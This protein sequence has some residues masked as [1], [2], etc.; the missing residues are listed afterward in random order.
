MESCDRGV[1]EKL[2]PDGKAEIVVTSMGECGGCASKESC[3]IMK[4]KN[5]VITARY[6]GELTK[7]DRVKIIVS[8]GNRVL[9]ALILF[10]SPLIFLFA[11]YFI[12]FKVTYNENLSI[13]SSFGA[14]GFS[15]LI[16]YFLTK[17]LPFLNRPSCR[18]ER[19][20]NIEVKSQK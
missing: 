7:G 12:I 1:V 10:L 20:E 15:F 8:P 14:F 11:G 16:I 17:K 18:V 3:G 9:A 2:L 13:A 4:A 19:D 6:E 5:R